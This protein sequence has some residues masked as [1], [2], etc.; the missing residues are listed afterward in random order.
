MA[1]L[2]E[3]RAELLARP[4]V[5][6]SFGCAGSLLRHRGLSSVELRLKTEWTS[7]HLGLAA[8]QHVG[9]SSLTRDQT[10][11]QSLHWKADS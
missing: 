7:R 3:G 11:I 1:H 10:R 8:L 6:F 9:S 4:C 5:V 2:G